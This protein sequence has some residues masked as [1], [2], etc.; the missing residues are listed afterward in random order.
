MLHDPRL[1]I[2]QRRSDESTSTHTPV[3]S[4][5]GEPRALEHTQVFGDARKRHVELGREFADGAFA[6]REIHEDRASGRISERAEGGV[7]RLLVWADI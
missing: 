6:A 5:I 2:P 7:E 3:A 1:R 4:D